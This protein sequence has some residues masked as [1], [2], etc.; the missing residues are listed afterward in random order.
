MKP[1]DAAYAHCFQRKRTAPRV[2]AAY[3]HRSVPVAGE[4]IKAYLYLRSAQVYEGAYPD[5]YDRLGTAHR[6]GS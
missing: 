1:G 2:P 6:P 4:R 3:G 5:W